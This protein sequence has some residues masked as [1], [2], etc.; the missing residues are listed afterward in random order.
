MRCF[1]SLLLLL[2]VSHSSFAQD[3]VNVKNDDELRR[4]LSNLRPGTR[5]RIAPGRY[6]GHIFL[7]RV[8]GTRERTI[9]IEGTDPDNPPVFEGG[10]EGWHLTDCAYLALRHLIVQGQSSMGVSIDDGGSYETPS[11]HLLLEH[12]LVRRIGPTGVAAD[13]IKLTGTN[14]FMVRNCSVTGWGGTGINLVGSHQGIIEG[15]TLRGRDSF[16][17]HAGIQTKGGS[18]DIMIRNCRL[19]HAGTRAVQLGGQ[20]SDPFFR[21]RDVTAEAKNITLERTTIIGSETAVSFVGVD[22]ATVRYNTLYHPGR[23]PLRILQET[24]KANF[25]PSR[26]GVFER[27]LIVYRHQGQDTMVNVGRGTAPETFRFAHNAWYSEDK[28][29]A[30]RPQLPTPEQ[31]GQYGVNPQLAAA[32]EGNYKPTAAALQAYGADA[33]Q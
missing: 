4:A 15:C 23:W 33:S 29:Q 32:S 17:Q 2:M 5:V 20:T 25:V 10:N 21:P 12:L 3:V 8:Q 9:I 24:R 31:N 22:G 30:S 16:S 14:R 7:N 11:H 19:E 26:N 1:I 28:P 6:R 13:G 18:S 27:N